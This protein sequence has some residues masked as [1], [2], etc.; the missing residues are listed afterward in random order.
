M[1]ELSGWI[2][3]ICAGIVV[4]GIVTP[5]IPSEKFAQAMK[6]L[7]GLFVLTCLLS[8]IRMNFDL[9]KIDIEEA[10]QARVLAAEEFNNQITNVVDKSSEE[11]VE[12]AVRELINA[13]GLVCSYL[14]IN[15]SAEDDKT[16][17]VITLP[18]EFSQYS[19]RWSQILSY[20]LSITVKFEFVEQ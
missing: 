2:F 16:I 15:I 11:I 10:E 7:L 18:T 8:P 12:K 17:A 14:N 13:E 5:L 9:P 4:C 3:T 6:P 1:P 19:Q 20:Q